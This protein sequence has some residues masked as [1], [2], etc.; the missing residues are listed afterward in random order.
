MKNNNKLF[1]KREW[2]IR[3]EER[4]RMHKL[5]LVKSMIWETFSFALTF[6]VTYMIY[7]N[8]SSSLMVSIVLSTIKVALM[9]MYEILW[10]RIYSKN[11]ENA[12]R[13]L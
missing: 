10:I 4:L 13:S 5:A 2:L 11:K 12:N 7:R 9:S 1:K 3:I 6:S 8:V